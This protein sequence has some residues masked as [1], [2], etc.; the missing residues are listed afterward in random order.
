MRGLSFF[1]IKYL[2]VT[3]IS[4]LSDLYVPSQK[5]FLCWC[6]NESPD[7]FGVYTFLVIDWACNYESLAFMCL[8]D[9]KIKC[10]SF[11]KTDF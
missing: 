8:Q 11:F 6:S 1:F 5:C 4:G 9:T 2:S 3:A 10:R 7:D